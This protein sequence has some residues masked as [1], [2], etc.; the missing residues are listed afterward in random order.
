MVEVQEVRA[1]STN[2]G[3]SSGITFAVPRLKEDFE[4]LMVLTWDEQPVMQPARS[5][6][7]LTA[8]HGFRDASG[9]GYGATVEKPDGIHWCY[10]LWGRD[11]ENKSSNYRDLRYL[12]ETVEEETQAG[13][14]DHGKL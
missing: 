2:V 13:Y 9:A 14:L 11:A 7:T 1:D 3:P 12:V 6:R 8:Y 10:G 4:A 5:R